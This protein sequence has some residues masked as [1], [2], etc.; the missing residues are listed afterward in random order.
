MI[1]RVGLVVGKGE[2]LVVGREGAAVADPGFGRGGG[3]AQ[4]KAWL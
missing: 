4:W 3:G 1:R 2:E